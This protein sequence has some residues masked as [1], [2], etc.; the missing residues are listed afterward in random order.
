MSYVPKPIDTT[1]VALPDEIAALSEKLARNAHEVWASERIAAG[2][3]LGPERNDARKE[4][5]SLV[6]YE[7]LSEAEKEYDRQVSMQSIKAILA[8]GF[9]IVPG[10]EAKT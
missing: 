10:R 9:R 8:M 7:Q 3:R 6:P 4:H 2:W 5:P 1:H